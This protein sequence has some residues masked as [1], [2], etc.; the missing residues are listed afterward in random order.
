MKKINQGAKC[1]ILGKTEIALKRA[2]GMNKEG[3][4]EC[5]LSAIL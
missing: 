1:A 2:A 4:Q 5:T 3:E